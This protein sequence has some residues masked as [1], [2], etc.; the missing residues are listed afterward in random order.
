LWAD[1]F[2]DF[3]EEKIS[4]KIA[5]LP[6]SDSRNLFIEFATA[7]G[8]QELPFGKQVLAGSSSI[9]SQGGVLPQI[10]FT[11]KRAHHQTIVV[12]PKVT[13]SG[14]QYDPKSVEFFPCI[15]FSP[16]AAETPDENAR[17]FSNLDTVGES[18]SVLEVLSHEFSF[19]DG[20]SI[21]YH[22]GI[23]MVFVECPA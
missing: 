7:A 23:P 20:L 13:T 10:Q 21:E 6:N 15:W 19:I 2:Y 17:R 14:L 9:S 8:T 16:G 18:N 3:K 5:G 1:L 11:W 22:A 4:I 12:R